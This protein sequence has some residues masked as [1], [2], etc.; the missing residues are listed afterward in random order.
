M[1]PK[2]MMPV[3][4]GAAIL[5]VGGFFLLNQQ[6]F[7][8]QPTPN[9][10][11][12]PT[13]APYPKPIG[14]IPADWLTYR[15]EEFGFE[16]KYPPTL[17]VENE[18]VEKD[19]VSFANSDSEILESVLS[20]RVYRDM[21]EE[22]VR[23]EI[24]FFTKPELLQVAP[25]LFPSDRNPEEIFNTAQYWM[26]WSA[27]PV[28]VPVE[29][30]SV[31]GKKALTANVDVRLHLKEG[32]YCCLGISRELLLFEDNDTYVWLS[33]LLDDVSL[34]QLLSTFRLVDQNVEA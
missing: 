17:V 31:N 1:S 33:T 29:E 14:E 18:N 13:P 24:G 26:P 5:L 2:I 4:L 21:N 10:T 32:G 34:K 23:R 30:T 27:G 11:P 9:P 28:P 3:L 8:P 20:I 22:E 15:N 16:V 25:H 12:A 7:E 6:G 19:S